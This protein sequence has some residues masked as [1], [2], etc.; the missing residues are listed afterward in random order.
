MLL[1]SYILI[2][3]NL[4]TDEVRYSYCGHLLHSFSKFVPLN[5]FLFSSSLLIKTS[6]VRFIRQDHEQQKDN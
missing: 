2:E 6:R 3:W 4:K 5:I 1:R